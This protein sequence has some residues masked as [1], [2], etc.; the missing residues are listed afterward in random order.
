MTNK[1]L[2]ILISAYA[3]SPYRGSEPGIG[4]N[5]IREI[6][7]HH[8][9]TVITEELE[10]K[11]D[12]QE[13]LKI[14]SINNNIDFHFIRRK[15]YDVLRKI[16]PPSYYW[17]YRIW[18]K[19]AYKLA[20]KLDSVE[21]FDIIHQ[22][23]M[24]GFREPGYLWKMNKPFVWGPIGGLE[25]S[26][27]GFLPFLGFKGMIYYAGRNLMNSWQRE[28]K[29]R[30]KGAANHKNSALIAATPGISEIIK[31]LW[32]KE[33]TVICEVGQDINEVLT[34]AHRNNSEPIRI[35]WSGLH[36]PRKNL[37][38]LLRS[39]KNISV[40]YKLHILGSGNMTNNW[41][42]IAK[43]M[44]IDEHCIWHGWL[45]RQKAIEIMKSGHI[46]CITSISDLTATVTL[47][48]LSLGLPIITLDHLG[49]KHVVTD[50][51]GIKIPV[52]TPNE[53]SIK[54][55][56]AIEKLSLNEELRYQLAQGALKRSQDFSWD[57]K[58]KQ[59]D[60]IYN[61]LVIK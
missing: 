5:F 41:K 31:K 4:W 27:W 18:H 34:P 48:A 14:N 52:T 24:S 56:N 50:K 32:K 42:K 30:P 10:F 12:I 3:C 59:L 55:S 6:A 16:W 61:S 40:E 36:I 29:K 60:I 9:L 23:N 33:S 22:L 46:F 7:K 11:N 21:D 15:H 51:C 1:P 57:K 49:F 26:P 53:A 45:D 37:P 28:F 54:I 25:N 17:F 8:Q 38:L 13:Y 20:N 43:K 39:I 47:E 58:I 35:V 44:S 2:K 19:K